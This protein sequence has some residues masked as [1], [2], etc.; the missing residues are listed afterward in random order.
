MLRLQQDATDSTDLRQ[1]RRT[2]GEKLSQ[3]H[4][5]QQVD[6]APVGNK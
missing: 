1:L 5:G 3:G 2:I 6:V 4:R